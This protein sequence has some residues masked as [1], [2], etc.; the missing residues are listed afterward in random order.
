MA[1]VQSNGKRIWMGALGS[2]KNRKTALKITQNRKTAIDFD[3]NRKPHTKP[4]KPKIYTAQFSPN[5]SLD[6]KRWWY[7]EHAYYTIAHHHSS[8]Y[9]IIKVSLSMACYGPKTGISG[10]GPPRRIYKDPR[11]NGKRRHWGKF[12]VREKLS[13]CTPPLKI[14]N[15]T[16]QFDLDWL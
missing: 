5:P 2:I 10:L 12:C 9:N 16:F 13:R 4:S 6:L 3:Q 15:P 1:R 11:L 7:V 14:Q 8:C